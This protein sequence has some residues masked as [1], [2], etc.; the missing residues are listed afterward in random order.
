MAIL[1]L[2][3]QSR[4]TA[5]SN[6][7]IAYRPEYSDNVNLSAT[8]PQNELIN[9]V[10]FGFHWSKRSSKFDGRVALEAESR[11]YKNNTFDDEFLPRL[12]M[13][14]NWNAVP[15]RFTWT[16]QDFARQETIV[17]RAA[18]TPANEQNVNVFLTGPDGS[19]HFGL[20]NSLQLGV[21]YGRTDFE[22][23][24]EDSKRAAGFARWIYQLSSAA[25][26]SFNVDVSSV[27]FKDESLLDFDRR[28][29]FFRVAGQTARSDLVLD[30]GDTSIDI[31]DRTGTEPLV[32]FSW[33]RRLTP[34]STMGIL[35]AREVSDAGR[36]LLVRGVTDPRLSPEGG[37]RG[38]LFIDKR[39]NAFYTITGRRTSATVT[40]FAGERD[41]VINTQDERSLGGNFEIRRTLRRRLL[42]SFFLNA[43]KQEFPNPPEQ[44]NRDKA[45]GLRVTYQVGRGTFVGGGVAWRDRNSDNP[46][47][48]YRETRVSLEIGYNSRRR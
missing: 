18:L 42:G 22:I 2:A 1:L 9:T 5:E 8:D 45:L 44:I 12:E 40:F 37:A 7:S 6:F 15:D 19:F 34:K 27:D 4:A 30:V 3:I 31:D 47:Q 28:D 23:T 36:N 10:D 26:L 16:V 20:R 11:N 24:N 38:N 29:L 14:L 21:R 39:V 43:E 48:N 17:N 32:R 46:T 41:F 13:I 35:L 25:T 33:N